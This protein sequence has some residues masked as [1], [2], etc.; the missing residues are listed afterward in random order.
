MGC[1]A[2]ASEELLS[3]LDP[4]VFDPHIRDILFTF[5]LPSPSLLPTASTCAQLS[6]GLTLF[7]SAAGCRLL[8]RST[9]HSYSTSSFGAIPSIDPPVIHPATGVCSE[10]VHWSSTTSLWRLKVC[11]SDKRL[12]SLCIHRKETSSSKLRQR[13]HLHLVKAFLCRKPHL[14]IRLG[15]QQHIASIF[16][17]S[18]GI[19]SGKFRQIQGRKRKSQRSLS[20]RDSFVS[21]RH[22]GLVH[23]QAQD[24]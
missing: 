24:P 20:L 6:F 12:G 11:S 8:V 23:H 4:F 21:S 3:P 17:A 18:V 1:G 22:N 10:A 16:T 5:T 19:L 15:H 14:R 9:I 7:T 13:K 2:G